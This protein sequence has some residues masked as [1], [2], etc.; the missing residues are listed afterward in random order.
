M[1]KKVLI[2]ILF[3]LPV[4]ASH[5]Q[6]VQLHYDLRHSLHENKEADLSGKDFLM[7][8]VEMFRPDRWGS[9]FFFIDMTYAGNKGGINSAYWEIARDIRFWK[10]PVAIHVEYNGGL[11]DMSI[12]NAYLAGLSWSPSLGKLNLNT[13]LAYKYNAFE[14]V[15][16]D[17]Q[18]TVSW[19]YI[20]QGKRFTACGYVDVWTENKDFAGIDTGKR[21]IVMS[22]PQFWFNVT[23]HFSTGS[24]IGIN[25]NFYGGKIFVLP[26]IAVKWVF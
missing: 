9:T 13:Y 16:H 23:E 14:K 2:T 24:E 21:V 12:P 4:I 25:Y 17:V 26:T 5:A 10:T 11:A 20:T 18:W 8:T 1:S 7:T 22:Q 15:S 3:A 6:N 19:H